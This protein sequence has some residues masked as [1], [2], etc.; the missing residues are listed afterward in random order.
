M[1]S[2]FQQ[3]NNSEFSVSE[4]TFVYYELVSNSLIIRFNVQNIKCHH[5]QVTVASDQFHQM[6]SSCTDLITSS[7]S[8]CVTIKYT[9]ILK[10]DSFHMLNITIHKFT[11]TDNL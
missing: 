4:V 2:Y 1:V 11:I 3:H 5:F 10:I 6:D 8:Q 7:F 9:F